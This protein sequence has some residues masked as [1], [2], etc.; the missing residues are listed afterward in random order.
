MAG[1]HE[2]EFDTD[3][4]DEYWVVVWQITQSILKIQYF[5]YFYDKS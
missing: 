3:L 5:K 1:G 4:G 2:I